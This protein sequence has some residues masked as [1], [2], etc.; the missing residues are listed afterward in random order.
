LTK[1]RYLYLNDNCLIGD[2]ILESLGELASLETIHFE[3]CGMSGAL[4][5]SGQQ[6][7]N[8]KWLFVLMLFVLN[9]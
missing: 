8:I 4:Q 3:S 5:S 9:Y 7:V 1:L 2:N 6:L